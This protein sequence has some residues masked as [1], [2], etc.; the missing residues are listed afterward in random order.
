MI[1]PHRQVF[2]CIQYAFTIMYGLKF[3]KYLAG[4]VWNIVPFEIKN[5]VNHEEFSSK[6]KSW[7]P[8]KC[9]CRLCLTYSQQVI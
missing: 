3:L 6:I 1:S 9:P 8:G 7:K 2:H 4:K 5:D